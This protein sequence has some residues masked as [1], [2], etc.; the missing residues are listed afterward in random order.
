MTNHVNE[1]GN[2]PYAASALIFTERG[3]VVSVSRKY[4]L[5]DLGLPGGKLDPGESFEQAVVRETRE[6]TNLE[7][8]EAI[9][10]FGDYC[11]NPGIHH[12]HWCLTFICR[13]RGTLKAMEKG[14]VVLVPPWRLVVN[15][16]G[17]LNSFG[18]YN[19]QV[20]TTDPQMDARKFASPISAT[21]EQFWTPEKR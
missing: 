4:D 16:W 13:A 8:V 17:K 14:R 20:L 1:P 7:I 15:E 10:L 3:L 12:V 18:L 11:G 6:E 9:P 5:D 2:P 21:P 19:Q